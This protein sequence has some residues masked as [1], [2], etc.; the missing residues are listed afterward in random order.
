M[1]ISTFKEGWE[2]RLARLRRCIAER[3]DGPVWL[4]TIRIRI[5]EFVS[6]RHQKEVEPPAAGL[7]DLS[8]PGAVG[9][10][11][12]A[13]RSVEDTLGPAMPW[14]A[15]PLA[16][17]AFPPRMRHMINPVLER[18]QNVN[19]ANRT[20]LDRGA[21]LQD[22]WLWWREEWCCRSSRCG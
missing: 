14:H 2:E 13:D 3:P 1:V 12:E 6:A 5:L 21:P 8:V 15:A 11:D 17:S 19:D 4:W 9:T 20:R 18:L 7:R 22:V 16:I 10:L